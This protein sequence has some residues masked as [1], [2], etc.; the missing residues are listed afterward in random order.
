[1]LAAKMS[2]SDL[3]LAEL[4]QHRPP[5]LKFCKGPPEALYTII[6]EDEDQ[7][8]LEACTVSTYEDLNAYEDEDRYYDDQGRVSMPINCGRLLTLSRL[9]HQ[10]RH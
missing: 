1:M 2:A 4:S 3:P 6:E 7:E 9:E 5:R 10:R 8:N